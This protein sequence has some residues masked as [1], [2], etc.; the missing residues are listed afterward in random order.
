MS[1]TKFT[2]EEKQ[3]VILYHLEHVNKYKDWTLRKTA[4]FYSVHHQTIKNWVDIYKEKG[5]EG[6]LD[7]RK[8][9]NK[10][11]ATEKG[12]NQEIIKLN[13]E[14]KRKDRTLK[15]AEVEIEILK[16]FHAFLKNQ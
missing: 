13:Q 12:E 9:N 1:K 11:T 15:K 8:H 7:N 10:L 3:K 14:L 5:L 6:L 2:I 4:N 16:K